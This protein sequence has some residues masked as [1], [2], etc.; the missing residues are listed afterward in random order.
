MYDFLSPFYIFITFSHSPFYPLKLFFSVHSSFILSSIRL[1]NLSLILQGFLVPKG[2][3]V[4]YSIRETQH[5]SPLYRF[6]DRFDP[7]RWLEIDKLSRDSGTDAAR[8]HYIPFGYGARH[9]IGLTYAKLVMK[10]FLIELVQTCSWTLKNRDIKML[11]IPATV[12]ADY[13]PAT[14]T[15][16]KSA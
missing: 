7:D 3:T 8:F 1:I 10:I 6:P 15:W 14:F 5:T 13:L 9:C 4:I 12:P 2:W 11:Y 16:R